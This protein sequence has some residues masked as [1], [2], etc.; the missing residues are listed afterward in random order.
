MEGNHVL[1]FNGEGQSIVAKDDTFRD[2]GDYVIE[3]KARAVEQLQWTEVEILKYDFTWK[4]KTRTAQIERI[5]VDFF[6]LNQD[7]IRYNPQY[8]RHPRSI[9]Q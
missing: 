6:L 9:L 4:N 7:I 8:L 5:F 3:V 2:L 1:D